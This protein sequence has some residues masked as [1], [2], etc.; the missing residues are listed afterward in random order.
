MNGKQKA[1]EQEEGIRKCLFLYVVKAEVV[2]FLRHT[3]C[4]WLKPA[5]KCWLA[6]H[7]EGLSPRQ[8]GIITLETRSVL[9]VAS[10]RKCSRLA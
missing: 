2:L 9:M 8:E 6:G 7:N 4:Q 5:L 1:V 3:G 10:N